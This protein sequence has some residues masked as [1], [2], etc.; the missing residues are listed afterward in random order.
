[1]KKF[2]TFSVISIV[3]FSILVMVP[4]VYTIGG[5]EGMVYEGNGA[6]GIILFGILWAIYIPFLKSISFELLKEMVI[7]LENALKSKK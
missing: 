6:I 7:R 2:V 5:I 1:M 4:L 3:V